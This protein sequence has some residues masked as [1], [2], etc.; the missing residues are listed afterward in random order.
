VQT[1]GTALPVGTGKSVEREVD[2]QLQ[3]LMSLGRDWQPGHVAEN[4]SLLLLI[5]VIITLSVMC[6]IA[7]LLLLLLL[8]LIL[9]II[10]RKAKQAQQSLALHISRKLHGL[11]FQPIS[12]NHFHQLTY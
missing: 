4:R 11:K 7:E 10:T 6:I 1:T 8:Q 5:I 3:G 12:K 9:I 2:L